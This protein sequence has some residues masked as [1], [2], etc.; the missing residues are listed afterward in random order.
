MDPDALG[1]SVF[2]GAGLVAQ[3]CV[4]SWRKSM[5]SSA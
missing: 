1:C 4:R 3:A 2:M 5:V